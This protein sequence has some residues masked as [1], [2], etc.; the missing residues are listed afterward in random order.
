MVDVWG[1]VAYQLTAVQWDTVKLLWIAASK[2]AA[3]ARPLGPG[4][5]VLQIGGSR[6]MWSAIHEISS[7]GSLLN[8]VTLMMCYNAKQRC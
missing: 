8:L 4:R 3:P 2:N 5:A 1:S 7:R 6:R